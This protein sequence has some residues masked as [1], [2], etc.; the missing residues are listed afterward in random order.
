M[1][2][3]TVNPESVLNLLKANSLFQGVDDESLNYV[4]QFL[5]I[6]HFS[7]G[8]PI[9]MENEASD[10]VYFVLNGSVEVVKHQVEI[11]QI[12]RL[13][14][15]KAGAHFSEFS[16]LNRSPK[17][18]SVFALEDCTLVRMS[19]EHFL[20]VLSHLPSVAAKLARQLA[21]LTSQAQLTRG[22]VDYYDIG[23]VEIREYIPQL[24]PIKTWARFQALPLRH[25]NQ[26]L[27][28]AVKNPQNA[29][30]FAFFRQSQPSLQIHLSLISD[31]DFEMLSRDLTAAYSGQ[32]GR[33]PRGQKERPR[34]PLGTVAE[35]LMQ[36]SLFK[37]F[38]ADYR[39]QLEPHCQVETH[40]P[41]TR[42]YKAGA[43]SDRLYVVL[44][45]EVEIY[46]PLGTEN[47]SIYVATLGA[48]EYFSEVS[49]LTKG[50][51]GLTARATS[52]VRV[53]VLSHEVIEHLMGTPIFTLPLARDLATRFHQ[54]NSNLALKIF[55]PKAGV[56]I[57]ALK[58]VLPRSIIE[59]YQILPLRLKDNE[60]VVGTVTRDCEV[61]YPLVGR[62]LQSYRVS[63]EIIQPPDFKRWL[64]EMFQGMGGKKESV[65]MKETDAVA[66][67]DQILD[68]GFAKRASDL[69][70]EP[71]VDSFSVRMRID[72]VLREH[73]LKVSREM[74]IQMVN[75]IK[76]MGQMDT[77]KKFV[78]QDGQFRVNRQ[79]ENSYARVSTMPTKNGENAV[80]RLIRE[81]QTVPP[82]TSLVPDRRV[83]RLL[84]HVTQTKQGVF[85]ITGPTGSGK[86]TTLYSMLKELNRV[87]ISI[88]S[89]E[90]PVEMELPGTTQVEVNEKTGLTFESV[91]RN[92]LRQAPDVIMIGEIRDEESAKMAFHAA[93]TGHLVISTLHTNNSL[94]VVPRLLE[95]GVPSATLGAGLIGTSAQRLLR[96]ICMKCRE[97]APITTA[98]VA[99]FQGHLP[100]M[101]PPTELVHAKGCPHC[102][103]RG[104]LDRIPIFEIW[105]GTTATSQLIA[106]SAGW[107]QLFP[108][109]R[110]QGFETLLEFGLKMAAN[111]LTTLEEVQRV[112]G[113]HFDE[114]TAIR[115]AA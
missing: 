103:G 28:V 59:E 78:P 108:E 87:E 52:A 105:Q 20:E 109:V 80:M 56:E 83:I 92:I 51:H 95:M 32:T 48:G 65:A 6:V 11:K 23:K 14:V 74:G 13:A 3:P 61:I 30:L 89:V 86:S 7:R 88:I 58:E 36:T 8:N 98:Q 19:G 10:H 44:S 114:G 37:D 39:A 94:E 70:L 41:G 84:H 71:T 24:F 12:H 62:Y 68:I 54:I 16:V 91:L 60:L 15:L 107:A 99:I 50:R 77:T 82:L 85:L 45:G 18:A 90:D 40:A 57:A 81:R 25:H 97:T 34:T 100:T 43:V 75:R 17:S 35:M 2:N 110:K 66:A 47:T 22:G 113:A 104:Y 67:L 1:E 53:A 101:K 26:S 63:L 102:E 5:E 49:L 55:D 33:F 72:G 27:F 38:P 42:I 96:Q 106:D 31:A 69:Y 115:E 73:P 111:K 64:A 79:G 93:M 4:V 46:R 112:L 29:E 76:V 9:V 21:E